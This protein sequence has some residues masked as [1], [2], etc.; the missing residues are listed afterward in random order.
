MVAR[1]EASESDAQPVPVLHLSESTD[2]TMQ[3][4]VS[5]IPIVYA[6]PGYETRFS[7]REPV[8][9][10][11]T[12][13]LLMYRTCPAQRLTNES[14]AG[15]DVRRLI[16]ASWHAVCPESVDSFPARRRRDVVT[17]TDA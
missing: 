11:T 1:L 17:C 5:S 8:P 9:V 4:L 15:Q 6:S 13:R 2:D 10:A 3:V 7:S 12:T 16:V 14:R